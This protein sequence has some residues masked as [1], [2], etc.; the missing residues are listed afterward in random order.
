[1]V[2]ILM[3]E[4]VENWN[5]TE[6]GFKMV[7]ILISKRADDWIQTG[8]PPLKWV[9]MCMLKSAALCTRMLDSPGNRETREQEKET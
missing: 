3:S 5:Q 7:P 6:P 8:V 2:P 9:H 4:T 1:M